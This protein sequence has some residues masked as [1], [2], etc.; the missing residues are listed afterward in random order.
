MLL[1]SVEKVYIR[2]AM[3]ALSNVYSSSGAGISDPIFERGTH[4]Q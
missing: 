2:L 1:E 4:K 3:H